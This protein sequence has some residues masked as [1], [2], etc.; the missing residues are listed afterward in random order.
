MTQVDAD[1]VDV[2][3]GGVNFVRPFDQDDR[4]RIAKIVESEPL[5]FGDRIDAIGIN[6]IDVKPAGV[7]IDD[8]EG[9]T[10]D[11]SAVLGACAGR[12]ALDQVGLSTSQGA[13]DG[14]VSAWIWN[15][16]SWVSEC[17]VT[18]ADVDG[19]LDYISIQNNSDTELMFFDYFKKDDADVASPD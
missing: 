1:G 7:L 2:T 16:S 8:D 3:N 14:E 4:L 19:N 17:S 12:N 9:R 6:V 5:E 15:G 10:V 18:D 11:S 13:D